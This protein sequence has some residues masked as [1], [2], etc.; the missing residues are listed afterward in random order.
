MISSQYAPLG[1]E[2]HRVAQLIQRRIDDEIAH[3]GLTRLSW[4]AAAHLAEGEGL[5]ISELAARLDVGNATTGQLVDR[6]ARS[7]WVV[8]SPSETDRRAQIVR[9]TDRAQQTLRELEPRQA[10]LEHSIFQDL[11]EAERQVLLSLLQ[12]IRLR[13][14][15]TQDT[16]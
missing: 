15:G 16:F 8:R 6:M 12:R 13:L 14:S 10:L 5:T 3:T 11:T 4:M 9:T 1:S 7:G 2:I